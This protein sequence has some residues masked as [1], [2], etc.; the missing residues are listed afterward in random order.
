MR[1]RV[2]LARKPTPGSRIVGDLDNMGGL[3]IGTGFL[4]YSSG[5]GIQLILYGL[6]FRSLAVYRSIVT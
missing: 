5:L 4:V 1:Q 2:D 3:I 6:G